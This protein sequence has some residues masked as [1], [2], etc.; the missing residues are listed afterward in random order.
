[1]I[2]SRWRDDVNGDGKVDTQDW[3]HTKD[4]Q[5]EGKETEDNQITLTV[6]GSIYGGMT[7]EQ[8]EQAQK[9]TAAGK[10]VELPKQA[11]KLATATFTTN[12]AGDYLIS[13]SDE[14]KPVA[15]WK[16][17]DGVDLTNL[18]SGYATFVFDI[19]NKDQTR[20]ARPVSNRPRTIR[21]P[22]MFMRLRS[23]RMRPS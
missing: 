10:T 23:L 14:D 9:D 17:E 13:S 19:A 5:G 22:R 2:R 8:A 20:K 3:L 18:P 12:K 6:N 16:A 4:G 21:S 11:V 15:Q 1:M 7:R